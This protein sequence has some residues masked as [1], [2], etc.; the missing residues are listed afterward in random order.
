M[1]QNIKFY[2]ENVNIYVIYKWAISFL[3]F[4]LWYEEM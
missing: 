4:L 1:G 2:R 3:L